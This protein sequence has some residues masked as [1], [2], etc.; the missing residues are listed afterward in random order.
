LAAQP[1]GRE[2]LLRLLV[3]EG[4]TGEHHEAMG[5]AMAALDE[6]TRCGRAN[7]L[8]QRQTQWLGAAVDRAVQLVRPDT[9]SSSDDS[10]ERLRRIAYRAVQN[11]FMTDEPGSRY[12]R[13]DQKLSAFAGKWLASTAA[14]NERTAGGMSGRHW[15]APPAAR[16][17]TPKRSQ[18]SRH[19]RRSPTP[20]AVVVEAAAHWR[21]VPR[22]TAACGPA[23]G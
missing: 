6:A 4:V 7:E 18:A 8:T 15:Q 12:E 11:G 5:V 22:V 2:R 20:G 9:A 21:R 17:A 13:A 3:G 16:L 1:G 14:R 19:C 10:G 23:T